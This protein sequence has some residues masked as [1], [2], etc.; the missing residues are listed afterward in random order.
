MNKLFMLKSGI[1]YRLWCED[2]KTAE[3]VVVPEVLQEPLLMLAHNY[4]G[5]NGFRRTYNAMKRQYYWPGMRKDILKHCKRCHQCSLQNQ[6]TGEIGFDHFEVPS[7][8]MEFICMD[9][10]GPISPQTSKGN[11]YMLTVIDMMTGY[12][13]AV[14]IPDKRAETVCKAYRDNVYCTFGGSSRILTDNGTEFKSKEMRQICEELDIKQVFS[15]VYTPQA[16]GRLEG[17]HRFLKSCIAKHIRGAEVEWDDLI[18]L[19]VSAYNFFPC[20]SSKESPFVLMFGRDPITPIAKLLEP[21]LKFYGEKGISLR[22]D[23]LRKLY[24]VVAENIRKA[25]EKQPRQG[26]TPPKVQ[27]NDLVLVKDPESAVFEPRYMPNYR[28]TAIFGRNRIEVQDEKGNK[29]LRRAAHV[30]VC[31]PADK[32]IEQLPPQTVYEQYGR[33]SKLLIHPKDVPNIPLQLFEERRQTTEMGEK[34]LNM[35]E[36]NDSS[37]ESR[38][39]T[40]TCATTEKCDSEIFVLDSDEE[41]LVPVDEYDESKNREL[42]PRRRHCE[43]NVSAG[44]S[45]AV[46]DTFDKSRNRSQLTELR[47]DTPPM[48]VSVNKCE[49]DV[50]S[51]DSNDESKSRTYR[52]TL[53]VMCGN[54]QQ[55]PDIVT[56]DPHALVDDN[57]ESSDRNDRWPVSKDQRAQQLVSPEKQGRNVKTAVVNRQD[58]DECLA[59][60]KYESVTQHST[61][62][63]NPW[64]FSA[65]SKFT[66]NV[67][68]KSKNTPGVEFAKNI[69]TK[70][71]SN[72]AF[73]PEFNFFL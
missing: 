22:M 58:V 28:V 32:V 45:V 52:S 54:E 3:C 57:D 31:Q 14:A 27:V 46:V 73:K 42:Y 4:S 35:L 21:K 70:C 13:I 38:S 36:L 33:T 7:L 15:P 56:S 2:G 37:D 10:V 44:N 30:K 41:C 1:V 43:I 29:S 60:N 25:R 19:A 63:N 17:W 11:R 49:G 34:D 51:I 71:N 50:S 67:L 20:Q 40:Q 48:V 6:G 53:T 26:T 59:T 65:I 9:L 62:A 69:N 47:Q 68:G 72:P 64:L 16:N 66:S 24:T 61:Q 12:T 8:P 55:N 5:H 23:T 18:P 39:R